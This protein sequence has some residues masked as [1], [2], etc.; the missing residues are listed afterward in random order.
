MGPPKAATS[1][2]YAVIKLA[3]FLASC[4]P[5]V[6]QTNQP[7]RHGSVHANYYPIIKRTIPTPSDTAIPAIAYEASILPTVGGFRLPSSDGLKSKGPRGGGGGASG[8]K[9]DSGD[10][11]SV[12]RT[13]AAFG[14]RGSR[15][16]VRPADCLARQPRDRRYI[17]MVVAVFS[18]NSTSHLFPDSITIVLCSTIT[19][20]HYF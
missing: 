17:V 1:I 3:S 10:D 5:W 20:G 13:L 19:R 15:T 7:S 12:L 6:D 8:T 9:G 18:L 4:L 2:H 14:L 11:S 16:T